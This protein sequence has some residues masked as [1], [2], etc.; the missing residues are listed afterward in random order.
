MK[1]T[2]LLALVAVCLLA[3]AQAK[4]KSTLFTLAGGKI[5]KFDIRTST[6]KRVPR[7]SP[8]D[9]ID[10]IRSQEDFMLRDE[11]G[12]SR[13]FNRCDCTR[14]S[15][16]VP[17]GMARTVS[18]DN[19][20]VTRSGAVF[21]ADAVHMAQKL[22]T[23][24]WRQCGAYTVAERLDSI[25]KLMSASPERY[26]L[27]EGNSIG[28]DCGSALKIAKDNA[29]AEIGVDA[30]QNCSELLLYRNNPDGSIEGRAYILFEIKI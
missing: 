17:A 11:K 12:F 24:G 14:V 18:R 20:V 21:I 22:E 1:K 15:C 19:D 29:S 30:S 16:L 3:P 27:I 25:S 9:A 5:E 6:W 13:M 28:E 10:F 4:K 8:L 23:E 7:E 2:F 26:I